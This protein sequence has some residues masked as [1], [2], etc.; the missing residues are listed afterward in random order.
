MRSKTWAPKGSRPPV[1][2]DT[3]Y[4]NAYIFGAFCPE[5]DAAVGLILPNADTKGMQIFLDELSKTL[6]E[7]V[8]AAVIMDGAGWHRAKS[9]RVPENVS[10]IDIPPYSP[11]CNTAEKPWQFLKDN[12]LANRIFDS[13]EHI[14]DACQDAWRAMVA[15]PGRVASLTSMAH[16]IMS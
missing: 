5:R 7:N 6:P 9:L 4:E 15:E 11:E 14:L 10:P 3:R 13:Y 16:L 8:H 2:V 1:P 12:Y